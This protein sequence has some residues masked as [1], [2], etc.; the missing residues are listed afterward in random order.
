MEPI[1][2]GV[3]PAAQSVPLTLFGACF[4]HKDA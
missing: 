3:L 4:H 2:L 1:P